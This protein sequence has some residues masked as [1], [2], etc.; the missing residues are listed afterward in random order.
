MRYLVGT[1]GHRTPFSETSSAFTLPIVNV[2]R[3][4]VLP[5]ET[6]LIFV[7][8]QNI[9]SKTSPIEIKRYLYKRRKK[10]HVVI[11]ELSLRTWDRIDSANRISDY[12]IIP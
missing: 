12:R 1:L 6:N 11:A 2:I 10:L 9:V 5:L 4:F 8:P 7:T 3:L